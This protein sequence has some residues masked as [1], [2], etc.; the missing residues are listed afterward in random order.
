MV[1]RRINMS[2]K[3]EVFVVDQEV[4]FTGFT[5]KKEDAPENAELLEEET[6]YTILAVDEGNAGD[7]A[8]YSLSVPNPKYDS[9]KRKTKNN[10]EFMGIEV[11]ADEI[12]SDV[13]AF[14]PGL[15]VEDLEV[16][17]TY[18][19]VDSD[20]VEVTGEV[21]KLLKASVD[22]DDGEVENLRLKHKEIVRIV[23]AEV[24]KQDLK[25]VPETKPETKA[26]TKPETKAKDKS[27]DKGKVKGSK[28]SDTKGKGKKKGKKKETKDKGGQSGGPASESTTDNKGIIILSEDEEDAEILALIDDADDL[29]DLAEEVADEAANSDYKLAGVL[30][31]VYITKAYKELRK[32]YSGNKGFEFYTEKELGVHYRKAMHLIDIYAKWNKY[33]ISPDELGGVGWTKAIDIVRVMN[34]ENAEEL[35]ALAKESSVVDLKETIKESYVQVGSTP[36]KLVK[37]ITFKFRLEEESAV[38]TRKYLEAGT[39]MLCLKNENETFEH[40]VAEWAAQNLN[41]EKTGKD[42]GK[43]KDKGKGKGKK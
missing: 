3:E 31:H 14:G 22:I 24:P 10:R 21:V 19:F 33:N 9:K 7:E 18:V 38:I 2:K 43:S 5:G 8:F 15:P 26:K 37:R 17:N 13:D 23:S 30:Y 29:C 11:Y 16:G 36:G 6:I 42:T 27:K 32:D 35:I 40:I 28:G 39:E 34:A 4:V 25:S 1:N 41:F 12:S 20:G